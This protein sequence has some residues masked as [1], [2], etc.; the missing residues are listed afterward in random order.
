[1]R[2][3]SVVSGLRDP[4]TSGE[5]PSLC[6]VTAIG[7]A[8]ASLP[9]LT[10]LIA[11]LPLPLE[12]AIVIASS[13]PIEQLLE[14]L[15]GSTSLPV[16]TVTDGMPV[17]PGTI[18]V[19]PSDRMV[20][21]SGGI[22]GL[23]E[24]T[25]PPGR[26][27]D[28]LFHSL[29]NEHS[30]LGVV[31][32]G[33]GDDGQSGLKAIGSAG[34]I[35]L[36]QESAEPL[37]T[38]G[39]LPSPEVH[40]RLSPKEIASRIGQLSNGAS[41]ASGQRESSISD[42]QLQEIHRL[43]RRETSNDL[44]YLRAELVRHRVLRRMALTQT[45]R[46]AEYIRCLQDGVGEIDKLFCDLA[47]HACGFYQAPA[48]LEAVK[49]ALAPALAERRPGEPFRAWVPGCSTG[50]EVYSTAM[51]LIEMLEQLGPSPAIQIFGTD[52]VEHSIQIARAGRYPQWI[53]HEVP[54]SRLSRF[55]RRQGQQ[56]AVRSDLRQCCLFARQHLAADPP[57]SRMDLIVYRNQLASVVPATQA[58]LLR[59]LHCSLK[60]RG[61]LALGQSE[62]VESA[63]YLFANAGGQGVYFR[64]D[65][66]SRSWMPPTPVGETVVAAPDISV[67]PAERPRPAAPRPS[68][69][70]EELAKKAS[71]HF[72]ALLEEQAE[73]I[74]ALK[75][76]NEE[77]TCSNEELQ[78]TNEELMAARE[79]LEAVNQE[80]Q[81][82]N[83][84]MQSRNLE[85]A[86]ASSDLS[87]LLCNLHLA[88]VTVDRELRV[89]RFTR[90]AGPLFSLGPGDIRRPI[91]DLNPRLQIP[92]LESLL[93]DTIA[94]LAVHDREVR[95][96]NGLR[97]RLSIRPYQTE[98]NQIDGAIIT[99]WPV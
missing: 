37:P 3:R 62:S 55:F 5:E 87:T 9:A 64:R 94:D 98:D 16:R 54:A 51:M 18:Y 49:A 65:D 68:R 7:V 92:Q 61:V 56:Y 58:H 17:Q 14:I 25:G 67:A 30:V 83:E 70:M 12:T 11:G 75:L 34:G 90:E 59:L 97:Y 77:I 26:A 81:M 2:D 42:E 93:K 91:T 71:H 74:E 95:D 57:L 8:T 44:R 82:L 31:L 23:G 28:K 53:E 22:F 38:F 27:I 10:E 50:E 88:V 39:L 47:T 35:T 84:E 24:A 66:V 73:T 52:L 43:V 63:A 4:G 89:R 76:A 48:A 78:A 21:V 79:E 99:A 15:R 46:A 69:S 41:R 32:E 85:M 1:M 40:Y 20:T 29:S 72:Q 6:P 96:P 86:G 60:P 33:T 36:A 45:D 13:D 80:L 19:T